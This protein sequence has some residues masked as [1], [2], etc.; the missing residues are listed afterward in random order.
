MK[1]VS[2]KSA[3]AASATREDFYKPRSTSREDIAR[4][5]KEG[6]DAEKIPCEKDMEISIFQAMGSRLIV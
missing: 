6:R 5:I 3:F 4:L 1:I 2:C